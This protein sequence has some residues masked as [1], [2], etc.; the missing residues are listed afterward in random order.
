MMDAPAAKPMAP[1]PDMGIELPDPPQ[2]V[3]PVKEENDS[4]LNAHSSNAQVGPSAPVAVMPSP[5]KKPAEMKL[6][7]PISDVV[8]R[9]PDAGMHF[10]DMEFTLAPPANSESQNQPATMNEP[11][12][13]LATFAPADGGD[14]MLTLDSLLPT[15]KPEPSTTA[16]APVAEGS[17]GN[18]QAKKE[19][20]VDNTFDDILY[21]DSAADGMDFD[22][23]IGGDGTGDDTFDDLMNNRDGDFELMQPGEFDTAYFGIDK[24]E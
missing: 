6:D 22:F 23:S 3:H 14:G 1:F 10:T 21:N 11:S 18:P 16:S 9:M 5:E 13:D 15:S 19:E 17:A 20:A 24:Q 4:S 8:A 2:P 7:A 12:F